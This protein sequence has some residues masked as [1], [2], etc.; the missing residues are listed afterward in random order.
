MQNNCAL[1][2]VKR[3]PNRFYNLRRLP[4]T[5]V[6]I[7]EHLPVA[8]G[9]DYEQWVATVRKYVPLGPH[10]RARLETFIK[11]ARQKDDARE[12]QEFFEGAMVYV[13][14]RRSVDSLGLFR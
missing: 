13:E 3:E 11:R 7:T 12:L 5:A 4:L 2:E 8:W 10:G 6:T 1:A 14:R 9:C